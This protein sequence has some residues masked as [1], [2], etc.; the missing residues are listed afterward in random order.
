MS[1]SAADTKILEVAQFLKHNRNSSAVKRLSQEDQT[2]IFDKAAILDNRETPASDSSQNRRQTRNSSKTPPPFNPEW[3]VDSHKFK[4]E[5]TKA[6]TYAKATVPRPPRPE[7]TT[8]LSPLSADSAPT[9]SLISTPAKSPFTSLGRLW[10][11]REKSYEKEGD[12]EL[13]DIELEERELT[14]PRVLLPPPSSRRTDI[15]DLA[16]PAINVIKPHQSLHL[17]QDESEQQLRPNPLLAPSNDLGSL[18]P[19]PFVRSRVV[20]TNPSVHHQSTQTDKS[21]ANI[22]ECQTGTQTDQPSYCHTA[23]QTATYSHAETQTDSTEKSNSPES[24][25]EQYSDNQSFQSSSVLNLSRSS[26]EM[27]NNDNGEGE[28]NL[29]PGPNN[30]QNPIADAIKIVTTPLAGLLNEFCDMIS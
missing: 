11:Q 8:H 12:I 13:E 29:N 16:T 1:L 3:V 26:S 2:Y 24:S 6:L 22:V 23:T 4:A 30:A 9:K 5:F 28:D 17:P 25:S 18:I 15:S 7:A 19:R 27:E 20:F 14:T 10:R 21:Y